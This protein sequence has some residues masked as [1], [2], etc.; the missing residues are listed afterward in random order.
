MEGGEPSAQEV[1]AEAPP[2]EAMPLEAT[3]PEDAQP[4]LQPQVE[5]VQQEAPSWEIAVDEKLVSGQD[6]VS[7]QNGMP[8]QDGFPLQDDVPPVN[9]HLAEE[10]QMADAGA[11]NTD[12]GLVGAVTEIIYTLY[13]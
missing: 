13:M 5:A 2:H 3:P 11:Y 1:M 10:D 12:C 6:G 4:I 9:N 8:V 7:E